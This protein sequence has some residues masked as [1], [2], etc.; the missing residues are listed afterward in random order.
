MPYWL[1]SIRTEVPQ[2]ELSELKVLLRFDIVLYYCIFFFLLITLYHCYNSA[3]LSLMFLLFLCICSMSF[4]QIFTHNCTDIETNFSIFH[5]NDF[6]FFHLFTIK[7]LQ[8]YYD[9]FVSSD[10]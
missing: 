8:N 1:E 3:I 9:F 2:D 7:Y 6:L 5:N 4:L 10:V